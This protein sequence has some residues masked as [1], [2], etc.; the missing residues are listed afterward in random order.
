MQWAVSGCEW[1]VGLVFID[2]SMCMFV[3]LADG[4]AGCKGQFLLLTCTCTSMH[5]LLMEEA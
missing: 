4:P 5:I 3:S 1:P 2:I